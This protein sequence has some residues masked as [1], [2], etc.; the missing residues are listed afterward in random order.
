L[1]KLFLCPLRTE[2]FTPFLF[3]V[4]G[5]NILDPAA[6]EVREMLRGIFLVV[7]LNLQNDYVCPNFFFLVVTS[8]S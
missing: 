2:L 5:P 3:S 6:T 1:I 8:K 7:F 4:C